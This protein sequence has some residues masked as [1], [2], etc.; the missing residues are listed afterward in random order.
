[1]ARHIKRIGIQAIGFAFLLLGAAGL[2]LPVLNGTLF[3]LAGLVLLSVYSER[4]K[5]IL[6]KIGRQHPKAEQAVTKVERW[7]HKVVGEVA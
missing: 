2:I 7:V 5:R 4:A 1:M 6:H 3:L